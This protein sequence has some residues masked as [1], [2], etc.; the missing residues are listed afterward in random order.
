MRVWISCILLSLFAQA[1]SAEALPRQLEWPGPLVEVTLKEPVA[2]ATGF[3]LGYQDG[4]MQFR[5]L[6]GQPDREF[7]AGKIETVRFLPPPPAAAASPAAES[8][9]PP[10]AESKTAGSESK[11]PPAT[12]SKTDAPLMPRMR[13]RLEKIREKFDL[14]AIEK[15][16]PA[17]AE[18]YREITQRTAAKV[19][20]EDQAE[21]L[22]LRK[23]MGLPPPDLYRQLRAEAAEARSGGKLE[24]YLD[25]LRRQLRACRDFDTARRHLISIL[26]GQRMEDSR[27]EHLLN[28]KPNL[29]REIEMIADTAVREQA[30]ANQRDILMDF[31]AFNLRQDGMRRKLE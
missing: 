5:P 29:E 13:D 10:V 17:E 9:L 6:D 15:L 27:E 23:K 3:M 22:Q 25:Q 1:A 18:R 8:K 16:T 19:T 4:R 26:Y 30:R 24:T 14:H 7:S 21:F 2:T 31:V 11:S 12:E 28:L 20:P